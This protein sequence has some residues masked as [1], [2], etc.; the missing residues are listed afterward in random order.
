MFALTVLALLNA[1]NQVG[2]LDVDERCEIVGA[3]LGHNEANVRG[4]L[5]N[6]SCVLNN[7]YADGKVVVEANL[8]SSADG[9][10]SRRT[11]FLRKG[12]ACGGYLVPVVLKDL[13]RRLRWPIAAVVI[14][15]RVVEQGRIEFNAY[16]RSYDPKD[17]D[18]RKGTI[19]AGCGAALSGIVEK[20]KEKWV[21]IG[22]HAD[23]KGLEYR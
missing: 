4:A 5:A 18:Q 22:G 1:T 14:D 20:S 21:Y 13:R 15:L 19:G 10:V 16:W 23:L 2:G 6:M 12:E 3:I 7:D 9:K 8:V 11:T 17:P